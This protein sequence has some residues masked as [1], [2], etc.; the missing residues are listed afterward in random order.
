MKYLS[1]D[2]GGT[3]IKYAWIDKLGNILEQGK[4]L[5]PRTTKEDF[6]AVVKEIWNLEKDEK[7]GICLSLPGTI[8]TQ[9]GFIHQ[10][11][12]L[13]Y[14]HQ[15]NIKEYYEKELQTRV[16]VE[17][18]A[19]CAAL[20]EITCGNMQ[21]ITNGIVLTFGTGVGGC[22]I[23]DGKIYKGTH[24][25]SGEVSMLICKDLKT[26]G[27]NAVLGNIAGIPSFVKRVC[28]T[29]EVDL[30][31]GKTVFEWI[32]QGD[33]VATNLFQE[34]CYDIVIQ[35]LN[36]QLIL[37]PQRICLGGGVSENVVFIEG[38]KKALDDFYNSLPYPIP[39]L[40]IM[41]CYHCNNAN[42]LG[43]FYHF[44]AMEKEN[45]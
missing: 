24:L 37:D 20:A 32:V 17:N 8:N 22:N 11:G 23:I 13:D 25:L 3:F 39:H 19:R 40:E 28:N 31:D 15:L 44:Q 1:I 27:R 2:A 33:E 30:T 38:I 36:L 4:Q 5:T 26:N 41:P 29:K 16:E 42:L 9:T 35:L 21:G 12:S 6:L 43:A 7:A 18:D 10:G 34:Y 14:H 45:D